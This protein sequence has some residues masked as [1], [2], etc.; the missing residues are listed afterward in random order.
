M[1]GDIRSRTD[2]LWK[3]GETKKIHPSLYI[4]PPQW[5]SNTIY[6]CFLTTAV[7]GVLSPDNA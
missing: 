5:L 2:E 6:L 4:W 1:E 7:A 3:Q